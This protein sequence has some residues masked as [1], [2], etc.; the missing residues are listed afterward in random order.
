M[1]PAREQ[2][3]LSPSGV[4]SSSSIGGK[5][6]CERKF[7]VSW[8]GLRGP[9]GPTLMVVLSPLSEYIRGSQSRH[10]KTSGTSPA[11]PGISW[12]RENLSDIV[13]EWERVLDALDAQITLSVLPLC[14]AL[15]TPIRPST[16]LLTKVHT[17]LDDLQRRCETKAA[18]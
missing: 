15:R 14:F 8:T 13:H 12:I 4:F 17:E 16:L 6:I 2:A 1:P 7:S 10:W 11:P 3:P 9:D 18:L 5:Y